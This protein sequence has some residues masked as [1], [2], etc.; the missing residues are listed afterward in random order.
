MDLSYSLDI[1]FMLLAFLA[2]RRTL[3]TLEQINASESEPSTPAGFTFHPPNFGAVRTPLSTPSP[4]PAPSPSSQA[5]GQRGHVR[6][7]SLAVPQITLTPDL[8]ARTRPRPKHGRKTVSF[9]LSSMDE[10]VARRSAPKRPPTP[11]IVQESSDSNSKMSDTN[12]IE[13]PMPSSVPVGIERLSASPE[14]R[15]AMGVKKEW[16]MPTRGGLQ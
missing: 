11:Y 12:A 14:T 7:D 2:F 3:P 10:L 1:L 13:D 4:A 8:V 9:S 5:S 15:D 6:R 16:L